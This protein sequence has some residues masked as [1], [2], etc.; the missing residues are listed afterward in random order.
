MLL[1][2]LS[3]GRRSGLLLGLLLGGLLRCIPDDSRWLGCLLT[4]DVVGID[5]G[6][7]TNR[8]MTFYQCQTLRQQTQKQ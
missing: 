4:S 7:R 3:C 2:T 8:N 1:G 6:R 5:V